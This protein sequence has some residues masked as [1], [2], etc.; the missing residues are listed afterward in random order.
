MR[1]AHADAVSYFSQHAQEFHELYGWQ[2]EFGERLRLWHE[3]IDRY[4][5][6][7]GLSLDIG[8]GSGVLSF[9]LA[10]I[11]GQVIGVDGAP[12]MIVFCES[13]RQQRS[14]ENVRFMESRLPT[15]PELDSIKV[16]LIV[17]SSVVEYV[18]DL[19][20]TL[21]RFAQLLNPRATLIISMPNVASLSR[22]YQRLKYRLTRAPEIYGYIRHFSSPRSLHDRLRPHGLALREVHYYTHETR[23]A[24][25]GRALGLPLALTEDLFAAVFQRV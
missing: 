9:Y 20:Q 11:G 1:Q 21:A 24:R 13:Q 8:C 12:D 19:D 10:R 14:I 15:L 18:S 25:L 22:G 6:P 23:L 4:A 17:N 2:P 5:T 16:D 3:L 7:G